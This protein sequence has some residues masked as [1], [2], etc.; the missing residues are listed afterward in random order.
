MTDDIETMIAAA[1]PAD[2]ARLA[3]LE[4]GVWTRVG[5]RREQMRMGQVRLAAVAMAM[6]IGGVNGGLMLATSRPAPSEMQ[7]FAVSANASP[8]A[9]LDVR[10]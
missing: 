4:D 7:V 5:R 8:L 2:E 3:G 6:V 1:E 9:R 10:G